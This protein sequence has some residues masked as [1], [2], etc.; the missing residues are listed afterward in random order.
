M[1]KKKEKAKNPGAGCCAAPASIVTVDER[2]QMVL[3]KDVREKAGISAGTKLVIVPWEKNGSV[4]CLC[5][6]KA[7]ELSGMVAGVLG[8]LL[9]NMTQ[10]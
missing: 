7:D 8:P 6:M 1:P 10:K 3:P 5:L 9:Q 4:C 2:G